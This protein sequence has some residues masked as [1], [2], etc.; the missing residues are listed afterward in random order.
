MSGRIESSERV[1]RH[2][3]AAGDHVC[4]RGAIGP[5]LTFFARAVIEFSEDERRW[6][7]TWCFGENGDC[8]G[9]NACRVKQDTRI[10]QVSQNMN[11]ESVD[12]RMR[13]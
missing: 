11:A 6:L 5:A 9:C 4:G 8:D 3:R 2:Q 7:V 13:Y 1:L 10:V 12:Y